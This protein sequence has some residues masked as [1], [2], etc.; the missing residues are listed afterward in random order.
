MNWE[1]HFIGGFS[2][3]YNQNETVFYYLIAYLHYLIVIKCNINN[4][5]TGL[6]IKFYSMLKL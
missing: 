3:K 5:Q 1:L 2:R 6:F 4:N